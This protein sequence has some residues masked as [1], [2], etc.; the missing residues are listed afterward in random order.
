[1]I[2]E[3]VLDRVGECPECEAVLTRGSIR[4]GPF[5]CRGCSKYIRPV[6]RRS[7]LW[8]RGLSCGIVA[9]LIAKFRTG[10]DWPFLIFVVGFYALPVLFF[11]DLI[12]FAMF[13]PTKFEPVGS[14]FQ[15]LGINKS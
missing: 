13:L 3:S 14:P 6:R 7:Y 2:A 1:M 9:V 5:N 12:G 4:P 11:W 10:F 15:T 8:L